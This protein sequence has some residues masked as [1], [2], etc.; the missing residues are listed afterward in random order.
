M[1]FCPS[2]QHASLSVCE[3][4][5]N[6]VVIDLP[7]KNDS[8]GQFRRR[9]QPEVLSPCSWNSFNHWNEVAGQ[10]CCFV[11][12]RTPPFLSNQRKFSGNSYAEQN[13]QAPRQY[14][15]VRPIPWS[16]LAPISTAWSSCLTV[17]LFFSD[18]DTRGGWLRV[19]DW[20]MLSP[21]LFRH[22]Q[23]RGIQVWPTQSGNAFR[24]LLGEN[25]YVTLSCVGVGNFRF[26]CMPGFWTM[27]KILT[28]LSILVL[29]ASWPIFRPS[30]KLISRKNNRDIWQNYT[31]QSSFESRLRFTSI[32]GCSIRT[33]VCRN[34]CFHDF[35][36]THS[37]RNLM[38]ILQRFFWH[39][40]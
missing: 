19:L 23:R 31:L 2:V 27:K 4:P 21:C 18:R 1:I 26:R 35:C 7:G 13:T 29:T 5:D 3:L 6:D 30:W 40:F 8:L 33:G 17:L 20:F 28:P 38:V 16:M 15:K 32:I 9:C 12:S 37:S 24:F 14:T 10:N 34:F 39:Q 11:L 36:S 25:A 22:L